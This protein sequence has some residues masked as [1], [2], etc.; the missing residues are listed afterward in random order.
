MT[1]SKAKLSEALSPN[2]ISRQMLRELEY[3]RLKLSYQSS[4]MM[5]FKPGNAIMHILRPY[6]PPKGKSVV[7]DSERELLIRLLSTWLWGKNW[8]I[9][10]T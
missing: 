1:I 4:G 7:A 3:S 8:S 9:Q 6:K 2:C 5:S 10:F